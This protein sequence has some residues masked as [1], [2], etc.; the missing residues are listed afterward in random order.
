MMLEPQPR[1]FRRS[2][3][4]LYLRIMLVSGLPLLAA[5]ALAVFSGVP[6]HGAHFGRAS[7]VGN[8]AQKM[9][10]GFGIA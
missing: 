4:R 1:F 5:G 10:A 3:Y 6:A 9:H 2:Q 8:P 7:P